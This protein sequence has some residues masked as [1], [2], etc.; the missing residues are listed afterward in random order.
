MRIVCSRG[1][2]FFLLDIKEIV[3]QDVFAPS[4]RV[5]G[6]KLCTSIILAFKENRETGEQESERGECW[7]E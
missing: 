4:Q 5:L 2:W 7:K 1:R 6:W 3:P